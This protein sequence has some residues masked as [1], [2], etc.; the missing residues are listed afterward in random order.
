M[1]NGSQSGGA[2]RRRGCRRSMVFVLSL[3]MGGG[4]PAEEEGEKKFRASELS[5]STESQ[6]VTSNRKGIGHGESVPRESRSF[7][8][9]RVGGCRNFERTEETG[10]PPRALFAPTVDRNSQ[11]MT[12]AGRRSPRPSGRSGS[13][14]P[15]RCPSREERVPHNR[16]VR[17]LERSE[18]LDLRVPDC[19]HG[20]AEEGCEKRRQGAQCNAVRRG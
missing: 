12:R 14:Y 5:A 8:E 4:Q 7:E 3:G 13:R 17:R 15:S 16:D 11:G 9:T 19:G 18:A 2:F 10:R 20:K 1:L 6:L